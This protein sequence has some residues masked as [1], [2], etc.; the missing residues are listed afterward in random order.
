MES[1]EVFDLRRMFIGDLPWLFVVEVAFRTTVMFLFTY[2]LV[3]VLGRRTIRQLSPVEFLLVIALGSAVGDPMFYADVP[4]LHGMAVV[5]VVVGLNRALTTLATHNTTFEAR[6]E[7]SPVE[8]LR[9]GVLH[10]DALRG[11]NLAADEIFEHLRLK[12]ITQLGELRAAYAEANGEISIF[13]V[14]TEQIRP[15]LPIEPPPELTQKARTDQAPG[16]YACRR[17]GRVRHIA[18]ATPG[19]QCV[20][21]ASDW[22]EAAGVVP[23]VTAAG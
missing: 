5:T 18:V 8:V 7:G 20:C 11:V 17:C 6:I 1:V 10:V 23:D 22:A 2:L 3:R 14:P 19:L 13:R 21:G 15:G 12:G 4:L 16:T 9:D